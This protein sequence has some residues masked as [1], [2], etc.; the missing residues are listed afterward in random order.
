MKFG[1]S[2][3][4]NYFVPYVD[5]SEFKVLFRNEIN[6]KLGIIANQ[7]KFYADMLIKDFKQKTKHIIHLK[8]LKFFK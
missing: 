6:S 1:E 2:Y 3:Y 4:C 8:L 5:A 7:L